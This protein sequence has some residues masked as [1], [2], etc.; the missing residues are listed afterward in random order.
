MGFF[1]W[2]CAVGRERHVS[3]RSTRLEHDQDQQSTRSRAHACGGMF[4]EGNREVC[5]RQG[6]QEQ[7]TSSPR[8]GRGGGREVTADTRDAA[9]SVCLV[10]LRGDQ[11]EE[12]R[13]DRPARCVLLLLPS[14]WAR[15]RSRG[16]S[17]SL[18]TRCSP[19]CSGSSRWTSRRRRPW[20]R[21]PSSS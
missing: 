18:R 10:G 1:L 4:T 7:N 19:A 8:G 14:C 13:Q 11:L 2:V 5:C 12:G 6:T 9:V 17:S 15:F 20:P 3:Q 16:L 21:G